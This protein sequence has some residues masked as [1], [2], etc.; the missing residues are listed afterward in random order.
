MKKV[1]VAAAIIC[2][3]AFARAAAVDWTIGGVV[4]PV[5]SAAAGKNVA[6]NGF[7]AYMILSSSLQDVTTAL[8]NG[9]T[10][11]LT[12]AAVGPTKNLNNKGAAVAGT[13]SGNVASVLN[14]K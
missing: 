3:V 2:A 11:E 10:V 9:S 6:A 8:A 1:M 13:A 12:S 14:C 7:A 4:D 5:A